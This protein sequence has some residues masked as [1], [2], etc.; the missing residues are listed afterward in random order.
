M[1]KDSALN[2]LV[3]LAINTHP[4]SFSFLFI[5]SRIHLSPSF[6]SFISHAIGIPFPSE[7]PSS[8]RF[9]NLASLRATRRKR[10]LSRRLSPVKR[11]VHIF[12]VVSNTR[13]A[14]FSQS[15]ICDILDVAFMYSLDGRSHPSY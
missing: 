6:S 10:R 13:K 3:V 12:V 4:S 15:G 7:V 11:R 2:R 14:I 5:Y 1:A 8:R 9:K